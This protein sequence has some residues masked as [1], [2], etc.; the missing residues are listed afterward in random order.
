MGHLYASTACDR[1]STLDIKSRTL[2]Q[3]AS[4]AFADLSGVWP[5]GLT[6]PRNPSSA[7]S[8]HPNSAR[9]RS[10]VSTNDLASDLTLNRP[11]SPLSSFHRSTT[12]MISRTLPL[13]TRAVLRPRALPSARP[14][15][16]RRL[17]HSTEPPLEGAADNAFNRERRAIKAH[18]AATSGEWRRWSLR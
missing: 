12:T 9:C 1:V 5:A 6:F 4:I 18:A 13:A 11:S 2:Y 14:M 7:T 16:Q 3:S 10:F 17:A 8:S 15:V